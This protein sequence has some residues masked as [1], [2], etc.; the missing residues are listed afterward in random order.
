MSPEP[1]RIASRRPT[2]DAAHPE[3]IAEKAGV[4]TIEPWHDIHDKR[5]RPTAAHEGR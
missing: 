4:G 1:D 5:P 2:I 3:F